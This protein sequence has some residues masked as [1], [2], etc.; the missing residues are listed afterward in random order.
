[1][2]WACHDLPKQKANGINEKSRLAVGRSPSAAQI[3]VVCH[4][5][6]NSEH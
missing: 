2:H 6:S 4:I 3:R 1:M 5:P